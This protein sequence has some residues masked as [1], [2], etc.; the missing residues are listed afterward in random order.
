MRGIVVD[1][2]TAKVFLAELHLCRFTESQMRIAEVRCLK[3]DWQLKGAANQR[4]DLSDFFYD[5]KK[6][7]HILEGDGMRVYTKEELA[8]LFILTKSQYE[9]LRKTEYRRG[10]FAGA[11]VDQV[12]VEESQKEQ[13]RL[14]AQLADERSKVEA[15][16]K[17]LERTKQTLRIAERK[18]EQHTDAEP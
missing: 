12:P 6:L 17:E 18:L 9:D 15:L 7:Q 4:L 8:N 10:W 16:T 1:T 3:D 5:P 2:D 14:V 11:H 13:L